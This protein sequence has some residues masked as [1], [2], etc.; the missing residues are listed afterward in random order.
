MLEW[1]RHDEGLRLVDGRV[2]D[3]QADVDDHEGLAHKAEAKAPGQP[4]LARVCARA[5]AAQRNDEKDGP[6]DGGQSEAHE[7]VLKWSRP[8]DELP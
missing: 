5:T 8:A 1:L 7:V 2:G 4:R 6:A 3:A